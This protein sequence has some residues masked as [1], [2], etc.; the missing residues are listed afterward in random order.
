MGTAPIRRMD[1]TDS[2]V[3]ALRRGTARDWRMVAQIARPRLR[4]KLQSI[5]QAQPDQ[6][7]R[8]GGECGLHL[9]PEA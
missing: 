4:P 1:A 7:I 6:V 8:S 3:V 5:S 9:C 2:A